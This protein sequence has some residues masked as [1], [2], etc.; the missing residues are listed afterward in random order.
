MV[1]PNVSERVNRTLQ[2]PKVWKPSREFQ[3]GD[4]MWV[5]DYCPNALYKWSKGVVRS[6]TGTVHYNVD[7]E[8][9]S[10][11]KV[12]IDHLTKQ[13]DNGPVSYMPSEAPSQLAGSS[14]IPR[15]VTSDSFSM[16]S[17]GDSSVVPTKD[18][19]TENSLSA[20]QFVSETMV[21]ESEV[22]LDVDAPDT[23]ITDTLTSE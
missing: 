9:S 11:R 15:C 16:A 10:L 4:L 18:A 12:Y 6:P 19:C 14:N 13:A 7:I 2:P 3:Q 17:P 1:L 8:G 21:T 22:R 20:S 5:H 23:G